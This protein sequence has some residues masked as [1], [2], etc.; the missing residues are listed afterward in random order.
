LTFYEYGLHPRRFGH[1]Q[2][3]NRD[4]GRG[5]LDIVRDPA[6]CALGARR[7]FLERDS[8]PLSNLLRKILD[9]SKA[10]FDSPFVERLRDFSDYRP[11]VFPLF[12]ELGPSDRT[13]PLRLIRPL[14][15]CA[16]VLLKG[17]AQLEF[18]SRFLR[19]PQYVTSSIQLRSTIACNM[20]L[21]VSRPASL[22]PSEGCLVFD[23]DR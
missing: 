8:Q 16:P 7:A 13:I 18:F 12:S 3:L 1:L 4:R 2:G 15:L 20:A 21:N 10:F 9:A 14:S 22:L 5:L 11:W 23:G 19:P 6:R 17:T